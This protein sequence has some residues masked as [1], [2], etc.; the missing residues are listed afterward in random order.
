MRAMELNPQAI[1]DAQFRVI[2]KGYDPEQVRPMLSQAADSLRSALSRATA[3][4]GRVT[5]AE[6]RTG[7]AEARAIEAEARA[8]AALQAA[9]VAQE[10]AGEDPEQLRR[11]LVSAQ[12][13]AD[14][15]LADAKQQAEAI[16]NGARE[17]SKKITTD[18]RASAA[19]MV[20]DAEQA[21]R[22]AHTAEMERTKAD[23][24][25]LVAR[26]DQLRTDAD[27]LATHLS[28]QRDRVAGSIEALR[29]LLAR[30]SVL[31]ALPVPETSRLDAPVAGKP[32]AAVGG[33]ASGAPGFGVTAG[34]A[35][36]AA[37]AADDAADGADVAGDLASLGSDA[38]GVASDP[39][40]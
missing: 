4:E 8:K 39:S 7:D 38:A 5:A 29:E 18:A 36:T 33:E 16:V 25:E 1:A 17:E 12:K 20:A 24:T 3:A 14:A 28:S 11:A 15:T 13:A 32:L 22:A 10:A 31:Q 21:A 23:I 26:R 37:D 19:R 35:N 30:P 2:R 6:S 40:S 27:F 9:S 34:A